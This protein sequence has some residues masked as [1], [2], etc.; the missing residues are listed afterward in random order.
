MT[1]EKYRTL[2]EK[3]VLPHLTDEKLMHA[4]GVKT[5]FDRNARI[6]KKLTYD[7]ACD[8]LARFANMVDVTMNVCH[9]VG[10]RSTAISQK[11]TEELAAD[12]RK[13]LRLNLGFHDFYS[14]DNINSMIDA[15]KSIE[16]QKEIEKPSDLQDAMEKLHGCFGLIIDFKNIMF[17]NIHMSA[18]L[19]ELS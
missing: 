11:K 15:S 9:I 12:E 10:A 18:M 8:C 2:V 17:T 3:D 16:S 13:E 6:S 7:E 4:L 1:A 5:L 19:E 14:V